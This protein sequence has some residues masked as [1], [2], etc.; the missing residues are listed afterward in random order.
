MNRRSLNTWRR[1]NGTNEGRAD[2]LTPLAVVFVVVLFVI[3]MATLTWPLV[4]YRSGASEHPAFP[5]EIEP[6]VSNLTRLRQQRTAALRLI[7][8]LD[9]ERA[10]GNLNEED[11]R[12]QRAVYV[13]RTAAVIREIEGRERVLDEE[14]ERAVSQGGATRGASSPTPDERRRAG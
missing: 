13:R 14:I 5:V 11:Y 9:A 4:R 2:V 12:T 1:S 10:L 6:V 8:E 7:R 3:G